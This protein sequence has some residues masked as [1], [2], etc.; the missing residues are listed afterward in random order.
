M[1]KAAEGLSQK[2][3]FDGTNGMLLC[4][5]FILL[6]LITRTLFGRWF[7]QARVLT[8]CSVT[9]FVGLFVHHGRSFLR[10]CGELAGAAETRVQLRR[11]SSQR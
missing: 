1:S 9:A 2:A 3:M 7:R 4:I 11:P 8:H 5:M 6:I 10:C